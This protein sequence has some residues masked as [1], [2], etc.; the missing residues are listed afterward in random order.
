MKRALPIMLAVATMFAGAVAPLAY[1][2]DAAAGG[3]QAGDPE[4]AANEQYKAWKAE[5][6]EAKKFELGKALVSANPGTKASEAVAYAY[7][8]DQKT[9]Q[10]TIQ[11][12]TTP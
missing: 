8:F 7:I 6:D 2:Q 4:A 3:A 10:T 5:T 1:A 12:D 11:R 9:D